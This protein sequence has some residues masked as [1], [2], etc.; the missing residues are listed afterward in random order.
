MEIMAKKTIYICKECGK[1]EIM[2]TGKCTNCGAWNSFEE[3]EE[4]RK[5]AK[6]KIS[7]KEKNKAAKK[8]SSVEI[9]SSERIMT[10][11][12]EFDRVAGGGLIRD[13]VSILTARPGAG[14]STLL[15]S[16]GE[17]LAQ[18][19]GRVLYISGEESESQI[20]Q[21]ANRVMEAIPEDI[22]IMATTSMDKALEEVKRVDPQIIFIDSIQTMA[23]EEFSQRPG[24]PTQTIECANQLVEVCKDEKNPRA[25]IMVGHMTKSDEMA[26]LRT[27]EHLVDTVFFLEGQSD[28]ELRILR[29]TKNRFGYT[30]E[31]GLFNMGE[32]GLVE[33]KNP[34]EYF[35]TERDQVVEGSA[36][37][38]IKEGSRI[39]T[40]EVESLVSHSFTPY[41]IRIGDSLRKDQLNTLISILEE[42]A[43]F[44]LYDKNVILKT[45]G[46]LKLSEQSVNLAIIMSI[47]SSVLKKGIDYKTVFIAEVGLT[48]ELKKVPQIENRIIELDRLGF[49]RVYI[50]PGNYDFKKIKN[51]RVIEKNTINDVIQDLFN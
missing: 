43:N 26:G 3:V 42:R 32:K 33:V 29:T 30:G 8:L 36:I 4:E 7:L 49:E 13:S 12:E 34:F 51:I 35:I 5:S 17:K 40:V 22:Y 47:V 39:I 37:S 21:R 46:G 24:S 38:V 10:G 45:T 16:L 18:T 25:A 44:S 50:A 48:G 23:L 19:A 31:I 9:D 11:I 28:E 1:K 20:K 6:K 15:L 2:W 27:L 14:K 41:P